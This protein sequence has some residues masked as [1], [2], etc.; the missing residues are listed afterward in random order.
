MT[1]ELAKEARNAFVDSL[2]GLTKD[3]VESAPEIGT[4]VIGTRKVGTLLY[5]LDQKVP[6]VVR[7]SM[8]LLSPRNKV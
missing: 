7:T 1:Y 3:M 5:F 8:V 6:F 4:F 2:K